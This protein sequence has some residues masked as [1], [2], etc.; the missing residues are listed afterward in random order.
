MGKS[1]KRREGETNETVKMNLVDRYL[2]E[3][4]RSGR[5]LCSLIIN[6]CRYRRILKRLVGTRVDNFKLTFSDAQG[7]DCYIERGKAMLRA[8]FIQD[9]RERRNS[10]RGKE[11]FILYIFV[12]FLTGE[13]RLRPWTD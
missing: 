13:K 12:F 9:E 10:V 6:S 2:M 8:V 5:P 11:R 4:K 1:G 3:V 7:R